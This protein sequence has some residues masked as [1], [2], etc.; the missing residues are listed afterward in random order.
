[1]AFFYAL[2][3]IIPFQKVFSPVPVKKLSELETM[4][5]EDREYVSFE[6]EELH[7]TGYNQMKNGEKEGCYYY[8]MEGGVCYFLLLETG[9]GEKTEEESAEESVIES[10]TVVG[11]IEENDDTLKKMAEKFASDLE[12]AETGLLEVS[13]SVYLSEPAYHLTVYQWVY[14]ILLALFYAAG[15]AAISI[16]GVIA[17][18]RLHPSMLKLLPYG[19]IK[20]HLKRANQELLEPV[21]ADYGRLKITK[22]YMVNL[23]RRHIFILPLNHVVWVFRIGDIQRKSIR[24]FRIRYNLYIYARYGVRMVS[25]SMTSENA[26]EVIRYLKE[27]SGDILTGYSEENQK[28]AKQYQKNVRKNKKSV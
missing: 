15:I 21:L 10:R 22:H 24:F 26:K 7:Y 20:K 3:Y 13:S 14:R 6:A 28:L 5:K 25:S 12:W 19:S 8:V 27:Y 2:I 23:G 16:L 18:P 11:R 9:D 1:M 4:Y 17:E